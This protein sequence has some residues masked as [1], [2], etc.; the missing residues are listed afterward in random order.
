MSNKIRKKMILLYSY[1]NKILIL[2]FS[3]ISMFFIHRNLKGN[4]DE[5]ENRILVV[6]VGPLGD[7]IIFMDALR[8]M[9]SFYENMNYVVTLVCS[10]AGQM[11]FENIVSD[12]NI[13]IISIKT[14]WS[15]WTVFSEF[16]R[17]V[18]RIQRF[19][20]KKSVNVTF[21]RFG[22]ML[23]ACAYSKEYI[24]MD[25][26]YCVRHNSIKHL[27]DYLYTDTIGC[28]DNLF[29]GKCYSILL[30]RLGDIKYL[31]KK[32]QIHL[33]KRVVHKKYIIVAPL[34]STLYRNLS[35]VQT[36]SIIQYLL[37]V[38]DY[39]IYVTG[40]QSDTS[41]MNCIMNEC[42]HDRVINMAGKLDFN[43][44]LC[45][46]D[47]AR[48]LIGADSAPI[49]IAASMNTPSIVLGGK[50][51]LGTF[52]PYDYDRK[53]ENEPICI[54]SKKSYSCQNCIK[55]CQVQKPNAICNQRIM[56]GQNCLCLEEIDMQD[57]YQ[58]INSMLD[59]LT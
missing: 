17:A 55:T 44:F 45:L 10:S 59:I 9:V 37:E 54:Y 13:D 31:S 23:T 6:A 39:Y 7:S 35:I 42:R 50:Y 56:Q 58:A 25:Y 3:Y 14:R 22:D 41:Y 40:T 19:H 1:M 28:P 51:N 57:V 30:H 21:A 47:G 2:V 5:Y 34:A 33:K 15:Q 26:K 36:I 53:E 12:K 8:A 24:R 20:Y 46:I 18:K 27:I 49:H 48:F 52:L 4:E 43:D 38:T 16:Y 11:I 32:S 29:I